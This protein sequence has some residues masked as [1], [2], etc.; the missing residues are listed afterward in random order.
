MFR[1]SFF[2]FAILAGFLVLSVTSASGQA[3][4]GKTSAT[5]EVNAGAAAFQAGHN[6]DAIRHFRSALQIE[7]N[8]LLAKTYLATALSQSV[9]AENGSAENVKL[10]DEAIGLFNQALALDPHDANSIRN[11]GILYFNTQRFDDARAW[12]KKALTEEAGDADSAYTIGVIDWTQARDNASKALRAAGLNDDGAGNAGA[13]ADLLAGLAKQNGPLV[14]E[15]LKYLNQALAT[16]PDY[17]DAMPYLSWVY[18]RKADVDFAN[19]QARD[20]D[21]AKAKEWI[22]KANEARKA[23]EQKSTG[24]G[25]GQN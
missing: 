21:V 5:D 22:D 15:A 7:P 11:I 16:R 8:L 19:P 23:A 25:S 4:A 2:C 12:M 1:R 6:D 18:T 13:P 9:A 3:P 10:A 24:G 14:E 17:H 20:E